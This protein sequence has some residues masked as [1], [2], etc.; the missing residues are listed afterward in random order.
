MTL[1][2][3]AIQNGTVIDHIQAGQALNIM[4]L[5]NFYANQVTLGLN[6]KSPSI[7]LKDL[8]KFEN[9][10]LT[11]M[12]ASQI[13]IFSP[14]ATVNVI[15]NFEVAKKFKVQMPTQI[16]KVLRCPNSSCISNSEPIPSFFFVE[17]EVCLRCKYCEKNFPQKVLF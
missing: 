1:S 3:P 16:V 5:L 13:A 17:D 8:I 15:E 6:L 9:V 11:E 2:V 14:L 12:Q 10:F 4:R 7:G